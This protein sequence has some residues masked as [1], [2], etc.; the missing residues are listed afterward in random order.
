[1]G[2]SHGEMQVEQAQTEARLLA[3]A[4]GFA[5]AELAQDST[6][7]D[8][9]HIERVRRLA[10]IIAREEG[11]DVF[12]CALAALLH[13]IADYKI[14]GDEETG[15]ARVRNWLAAHNADAAGAE[16]TARVMEIIA[17]MSFAGGAR[18]PMAT[19]EGRVMQ[20]ADRLDAIGAIGVARAFAFGGAKGRALYDPNQPPRKAMTTEEYRAG[21][22]STINHFYEKLLLLKDRMNTQYARQ[23][24]VQRHEFM[25]SFLDEF[26]AEWSGER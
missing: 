11:A 16:T 10:E 17:T 5:R 7:H 22:S 14:A 4:E 13:D 25:L 8:F 2:N 1:M 21:D 3:A 12:V 6:G 15:L 24:A 23:L 9:A 20:D 26:L 19:L 18:P